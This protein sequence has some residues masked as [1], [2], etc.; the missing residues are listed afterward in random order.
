MTKFERDEIVE[1]YYY[2]P[3]NITKRKYLNLKPY[4]RVITLLEKIKLK[5]FKGL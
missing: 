5:T 2:Y 4:K 1:E 3:S